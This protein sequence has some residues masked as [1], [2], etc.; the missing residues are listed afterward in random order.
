MGDGDFDTTPP[1][2]PA[3]NIINNSSTSPSSLTKAL[4]QQK[5]TINAAQQQLTKWF[6]AGTKTIT[7]KD[8]TTSTI[9][10]TTDNNTNT[11]SN[12]NNIN[13]EQLSIA[14]QDINNNNNKVTSIITTST[15]TNMEICNNS[16]DE[17]Q[18]F[19]NNNQTHQDNEII[20]SKYADKLDTISPAFINTLPTDEQQKLNKIIQQQKQ[21]LPDEKPFTLVQS[22]NKTKMTKTTIPTL[23]PSTPK[24]SKTASIFEFGS[25]KNGSRSSTPIKA[26]TSQPIQQKTV[27]GRGGGRGGG[28]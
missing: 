22:K 10:T 24:Q 9:G 14:K 7:D 28:G 20:I 26:N 2:P 3:P 19:N 21:I 27:Y 5:I 17:M 11:T 25:N 13:I 23:T 18:Q 1:E 15:D 16:I 4:T 12:I 6:K 8:K